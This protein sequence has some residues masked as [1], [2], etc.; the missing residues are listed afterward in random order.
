MPATA[1]LAASYG[2]GDVTS[3]GIAALEANFG[4]GRVETDAPL[5]DVNAG[6]AR[7]ASRGGREVAVNGGNVRIALEDADALR[8]FRFNTGNGEVKLAQKRLPTDAAYD[9][10]FGSGKVEATFERRPA[11][12]VITISSLAGKL[13]T[14]IPFNKEG[15]RMIYAAGEPKAR[16]HI[17]AGS[18]KVAVRVKEEK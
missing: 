7:V 5:V 6:N 17:H 13:D 9:M 4:N 14:D 15:A 18:S 10:N 3:Q 8:V 12:C 1:K 16:V 11:D 2:A